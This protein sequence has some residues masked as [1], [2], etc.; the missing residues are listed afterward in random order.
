MNFGKK[1]RD[2]PM[3]SSSLSRQNQRSFESGEELEESRTWKG[4]SLLARRDQIKKTSGRP[5]N[6]LCRHTHTCVYIYIY[7]IAAGCL[8]EPHFFTLVSR[9]MR[10]RSAKMIL[11]SKNVR[12]LVAT[13]AVQLSTHDFSLLFCSFA[14]G[15]AGLCPVFCSQVAPKHMGK[16]RFSALLGPNAVGSASA[17]RNWCETQGAGGPR[18]FSWLF[19]WFFCLWGV[20]VFSSRIWY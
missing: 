17:A 18:I 3:K 13:F 8:I 12:I 5:E 2:F 20:W 6:G 19:F 16:R 11:L 15:I 9:N 14:Q 7:Y 4:G 1:G 10:K